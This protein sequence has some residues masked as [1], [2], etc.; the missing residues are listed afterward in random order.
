MENDQKNYRLHKVEKN[1]QGKFFTHTSKI[2]KS[3]SDPNLQVIWECINR[4]DYADYKK[5]SGVDVIALIK[6]HKIEDVSNNLHSQQNDP[7]E[8]LSILIIENFRYPVEKKVLE[9]P[10]GMIDHNEFEKLEILHKKLLDSNYSQEKLVLQN[11]S[12]ALLE[13]ICINSAGR[14]LK[15]ET[16]Y[17]GQ[18]KGFFSL[19]TVR[20][21]K[22][23]ENVFFDPWK[24]SENSATCIYLIDKNLLENHNPKQD[25]EN[26]EI[27]K[28]HEVKLKNL[29]NFIS[30]K[31]E[32]ES[33]GCSQQLYNF[34]MG[35]HFLEF[36]KFLKI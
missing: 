30:E 7:M 6:D 24:S 22:I 26:E 31:I 20:P 11:E 28:T 12:D 10:A 14:E 27:I 8:N 2:F 25:L 23:F 13:Q 4:S 21:L 9:F 34:A 32:N 33:Y 5:L 36:L 1:Y 19:P 35:L 17:S 29:I 18:F 16:G 3:E 15:E